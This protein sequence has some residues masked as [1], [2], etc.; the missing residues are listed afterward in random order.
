[1]PSSYTRSVEMA[2][3]GQPGRFASDADSGTALWRVTAREHLP[4]RPGGQLRRN[5]LIPIALSRTRPRC[6]P[7]PRFVPSLHPKPSLQCPCLGRKGRL[8]IR[9]HSGSRTCPRRSTRCKTYEQTA[10]M[11]TISPPSSTSPKTPTTRLPLA[12][13]SNMSTGTPKNAIA[14]DKTA[15]SIDAFLASRELRK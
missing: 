14:P 9:R 4:S 2:R 5:R 11:A 3:P 15:R 12:T 6:T 10:L 7:I 1:M 8:E 13:L